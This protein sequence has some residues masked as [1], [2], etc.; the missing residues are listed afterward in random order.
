MPR[1]AVS[2]TANV[3]R[4]AR[5]KWVKHEYSIQIQAGRSNNIYF[6]VQL[7]VCVCVCVYSVRTQ[8]ELYV[9]VRLKNAC[10]WAYTGSIHYTRM[11]DKLPDKYVNKK[12]YN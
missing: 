7:E 4:T 10:V 3:E 2:R 12:I 11:Y 1:D 6:F 8:R 9:C 5:H